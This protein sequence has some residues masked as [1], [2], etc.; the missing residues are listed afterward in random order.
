MLDR[1]NEERDG[2]EF[3]DRFVH[4]AKRAAAAPYNPMS[5]VLPFTGSKSAARRRA[6]AERQVARVKRELTEIAALAKEIRDE[7]HLREVLAEIPDD[8]M[9]IA[10]SKLMEPFLSFRIQRVELA[11]PAPLVVSES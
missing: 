2:R 3:M 6:A 1:V 11:E 5:S 7:A 4:N 10:V 8:E 9:R